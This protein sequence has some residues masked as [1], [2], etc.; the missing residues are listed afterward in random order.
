ME[1]KVF[2]IDD[3]KSFMGDATHNV[4]KVKQAYVKTGDDAEKA[5]KDKGW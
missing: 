3:S 4:S 1:N 2:N 5:F